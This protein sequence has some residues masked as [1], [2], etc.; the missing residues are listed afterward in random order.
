MFANRKAVWP[1]VRSGISLSHLRIRFFLS[2]LCLHRGVLRGA[3][4]AW[5]SAPSFLRPEVPIE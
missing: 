1:A 5:F 2:H 3:H 4:L